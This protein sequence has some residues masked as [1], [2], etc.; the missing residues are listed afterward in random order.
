MPLPFY[1]F[2]AKG[3]IPDTILYAPL[4]ESDDSQTKPLS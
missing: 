4:Y 2:L 3:L 1:I